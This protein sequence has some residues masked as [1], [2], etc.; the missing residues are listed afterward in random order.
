[1]SLGWTF[2][3]EIDDMNIYQAS[4]L[5]MK[6]AVEGL[7]EAP[8]FLLVDA[9]TIPDITIPQRSIIGGDRA[10]YL[11]AAASIVAKEA[12]DRYMVEMDATY[13]KYGFARH[14][15][16]GTKAHL[17]A[18]N[19]L[20]PSPIHRLSFAPVRAA[21]SHLKSPDNREEHDERI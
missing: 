17:E 12:R 8:G 20:G 16:Y 5:A 3:N 15:G 7:A 4:L 10:S 6:R 13:P 18:L 21:A 19:L 2:P 11:I 14:K 9:R 1:M